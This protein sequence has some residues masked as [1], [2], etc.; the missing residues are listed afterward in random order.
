MKLQKVVRVPA[1]LIAV[2]GVG[3]L[4]ARPASAQQDMDPTHFDDSQDTVALTQPVNAT[5]GAEAAN[6]STISSP[7]PVEGPMMSA[8]NPTP[9]LLLIGS[10]VLALIGG[11]RAVEGLRQRREDGES[12]TL[13]EMSI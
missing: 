11:A 9:L 4:L 6:I 2:A 1:M 13:S 12:K 8:D 7:T 5:P 10:G 3:L